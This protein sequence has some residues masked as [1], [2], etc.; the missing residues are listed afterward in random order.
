[1]NNYKK[2]YSSSTYTLCSTI[3]NDFYYPHEIISKFNYNK[4]KYYKKKI[5]NI[6]NIK[7]IK[8]IKN[9]IKHNY[10]IP[11]NEFDIDYQ[12][13]LNRKKKII[14]YHF[15]KFLPKYFQKLF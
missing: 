3:L 6:K 15:L 2:K 8:F 13:Y 5:K 12:N 4:Q 1:M 14:N 9:N 10:H 7:N 11:N